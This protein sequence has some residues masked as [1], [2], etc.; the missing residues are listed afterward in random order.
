[1]AKP[2]KYIDLMLKKLLLMAMLKTD[3]VFN[4]YIFLYRI[5]SHW[6][7]EIY[8]LTHLISL[9]LLLII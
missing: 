4:I 2:K 1:M 7:I 3:L 8:F 5:F 6:L 9:L